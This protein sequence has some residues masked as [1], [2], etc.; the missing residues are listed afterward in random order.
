[1]GQNIP[2][3]SSMISSSFGL[4]DVEDSVKQRVQGL[5]RSQVGALLV[6][7][8]SLETTVDHHRVQACVKQSEEK[9]R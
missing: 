3:P 6:L 8:E 1:M 4:R 9:N 7:Q 5:V 2:A